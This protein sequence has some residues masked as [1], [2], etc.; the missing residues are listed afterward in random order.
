MQIQYLTLAS[1]VFTA[2][3]AAAQPQGAFDRSLSVTGPADL[4]LTTVSRTLTAKAPLG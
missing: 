3:Y 1:I 4:D 2:A